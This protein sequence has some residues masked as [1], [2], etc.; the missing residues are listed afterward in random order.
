M[1]QLRR[2]PGFAITAVLTLA[3]GIGANTAIF[4]LLDQALLR[5]LP[6]HNPGELVMLRGTGSAWEGHSSSHGGIGEDTS[7]S[8]PMYRDL[9]DHAAAFSDAL[10]TAPTEVDLL[11]GGQA[12]VVAAEIVSGNYFTMLGVA[13]AQ[14]QFF[15]QSEDRQPDADPVAVL[16]YDF[17]R[18]GLNSDLAIVGSTVSLNGH[19]FQVIGVAPPGFRS[20]VWG[21]T[22]SVFLPMSML[23]EI[24]PGSRR[25]LTDHTDRWLNILAR[26]KPGETLTQA[27][28]QSAPLWHALRAEEL[29][30]LGTR[31]PQFVDEFLTRSQLVLEP[32]ARGL[33][34]S[35]DRYQTPLLA[36]MAMAAL[37]LLIA[38]VNVGSLLLVR[39]T[40]RAREFG[41]RRALGAGTARLGLQLLTEGLLI[42]AAGGALGL[43]LAPVA[44]RGIVARLAGVEGSTPFNTQLDIR[45]LLFN[46]A[47][48]IGFSLLFSFAPFLQL[49]RRD[50]TSVAGKANATGA[51]GMLLFRR[52]I[53]GLKVGLCLLLLVGAGLFVRTLQHL[54]SQDL[55]FRSDHLATFGISPR[56]AGYA[57]ERVPLLEGQ[58]LNTLSAI[59]GVNAAAATN[60]P[61]LRGNNHGGN[62]TLEHYTQA[63]EEQ[64]DPEKADVSSGYFAT[65]HIP[66]V[67]GRLF[68]AED[69][70][71]H[72]LVAI[73]NERFASRYFGSPRQA[74]GQRLMDGASNHPAFNTTIVGVVGNVRHMSVREP[75]T[76]SL[77]RPGLQASKGD[78]NRELYFYV[79]GQVA[80]DSLFAS[81]RHAVAGVDANL[82]VDGLRTMD[83]QIDQALSNE[84][85]TALLAI[86]FA[87]LAAL[88]AGVGLYGVLAFVTAQRTLNNEGTTIVQVTHSEANAA[89]G[90]RTLDLRDGWLSRD[91][92]QLSAAE[93]ASLGSAAR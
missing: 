65:M 63:P 46:F 76:P 37:V 8:Y 75:S 32:A 42:G 58:M 40:A 49:R 10:V 24:V 26:L 59:A 19:P 41:M 62:I 90:T 68:T 91:T 66:L 17:W 54:R 83:G 3:L 35:R 9:R 18:T 2:S 34:Y 67:A 56:L 50:I 81:I 92:A 12:R 70:N 36:V 47:V 43:L 53:V 14:G 73:V 20:V 5:S 23:G 82:A 22:P 21:Q 28:A 84:R 55:G 29:K 74:V 16:S 87:W 25:P 80:P 1:R 38:V 39:S 48:A 44:I 13:P 79:R 31:S 60:D 72:P 11:R 85:M 86:A 30:A 51:R 15:T 27:Q 61:E 77:Y 7:F 88:L 89:Y 64:V 6:V 45:L 52:V 93:N 71:A 33:S 69:D 57:P 78:L 4:S